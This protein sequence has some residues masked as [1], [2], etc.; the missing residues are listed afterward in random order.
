MP[1]ARTELLTDRLRCI[2]P[3][4]SQAAAVCDFHAR[5]HACFA[6]WDPPMPVAFL[7]EQFQAERLRLAAQQFTGG[8]GYR[9]WLTL[10]GQPERIVGSMHFSQVV[11]GAFHNAMLGYALDEKL[12]GRG[13]MAEALRAG[14]AEMFSTRVNLH[15]IQANHDPDNARSAAV[16]ARLG[17]RNEG[18]ARDYLF[19]NGAWR[20]HMMTALTNP[21]FTAPAE[22]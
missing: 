13:L 3:R 16:L 7:T 17:F 5:N 2:A 9:Y 14:I 10:E 11:R 21:E 19:I 20:D 22:W 8:T 1:A 6:R 15:R 18:L 12:H 4:P